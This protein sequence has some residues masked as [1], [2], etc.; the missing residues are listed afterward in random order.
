MDSSVGVIGSLH[1]LKLRAIKTVKTKGL[2][3]FHYLHQQAFETQ[4]KE[5]EAKVNPYY[6]IKL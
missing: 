4:V 5:D 2:L 6:L 1:S 3:S